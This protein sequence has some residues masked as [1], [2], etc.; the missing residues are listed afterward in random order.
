MDSDEVAAY[1]LPTEPGQ[2]PRAIIGRPAEGGLAGVLA[3]WSRD[4]GAWTV[5][6]A[7]VP[8]EVSDA[9][10]EHARSLGVEEFLD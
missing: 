5:G 2:P 9:I 6:G 3:T 10:T 7:P 4:S 8:Q 1:V